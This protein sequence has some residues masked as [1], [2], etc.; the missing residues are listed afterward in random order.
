GTPRR[1]SRPAAGRARNARGSGAGPASPAPPIRYV[2][3]PRRS[4]RGRRRRGQAGSLQWSWAVGLLADEQSAQRR[5]EVRPRRTESMDEPFL[6]PGVL[7]VP[8]VAIGVDL[9]W[10]VGPDVEHDLVAA[11]EQLCGDRTGHGRGEAA[12]PVV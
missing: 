4:G 8:E 10:V 6:E 5:S 12:A 2:A 9:R 7:D 1:G 3:P 11:P